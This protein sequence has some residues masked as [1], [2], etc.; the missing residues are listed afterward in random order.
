MAPVRSTPP[1]SSSSNSN[2]NN[3]ESTTTTSGNAFTFNGFGTWRNCRVTVKIQGKHVIVQFEIVLP[4]GF[5]VSTSW[6]P[7]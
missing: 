2:S 1:S 6:Q 5:T 7:F 4:F 3:M